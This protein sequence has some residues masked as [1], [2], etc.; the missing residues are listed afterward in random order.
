MG[1]RRE[2]GNSRSRT[3]FDSVTIQAVCIG[4][5]PA[6]ATS[7]KP[8]ADAARR[9]MGAPG[10]SM[11][12]LGALVSTIGTL[13]ASLLVGPRLLFAMAERSQMPRWLGSTHARFHTPH[14]AILVTGAVAL[15]LSISS[16][17]RR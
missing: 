6:L 1:P 7:E 13:G 17:A 12:A 10:A 8:L 14:R 3:T 16:S 9:F 15:A 5:L 4:T 11:V 2:I